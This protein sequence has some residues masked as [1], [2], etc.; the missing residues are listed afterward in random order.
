[1]RLSWMFLLIVGCASAAK[2]VVPQPAPVLFQNAYE[3]ADVR[4]AVIRSID[5]LRINATDEREGVVQGA[6]SKLPCSVDVAFSATQVLVTPGPL[7]A[8][9][10]VDSRCVALSEKLT[11]SIRNEVLRP[12]K[13][14]RKQ[15]KRDQKAATAAANRAAWEANQAAWA[16][17]QRVAAEQAQQYQPPP[18][19]EV[20]AQVYV[21][22]AP[23]PPPAPVQN[24]VIQYNRS[25]TNVQ[26]NTNINSTTTV[27][28][29]APPPAVAGPRLQANTC[30][31][32]GK[33][34]LCPNTETYAAACVQNRGS[35]A[36]LCP[37]N[38]AHDQFCPR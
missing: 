36:Q 1:M 32:R 14:A 3:P 9:S 13:T 4:A 23:P 31:V 12:A 30:C 27:V 8:Q 21:E 29:A 10:R 24:N 26:S 25:T 35:L 6:A 15:Q 34:Y 28:N 11:H 16:E 17:Q 33:A 38:A 37:A 18:P 20:P 5:H 19:E 7:D 22:P 2:F